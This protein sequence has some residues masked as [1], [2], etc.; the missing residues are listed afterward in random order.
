MKDI[1]IFIF[2]DEFDSALTEFPLISNFKVNIVEKCTVKDLEAFNL[3]HENVFIDVLIF[4]IK[5]DSYQKLN[6]K[7]K[8]LEI[9]GLKID[10]N[11]KQKLSFI[12][13][14]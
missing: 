10:T 9:W 12:K 8:T 14:A 2:R 11:L 1:E 3:N 6:C 5:N 13:T 7:V 4:D